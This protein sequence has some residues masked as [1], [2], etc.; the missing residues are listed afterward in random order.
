M[1][2]NALEQYGP[3]HGNVFVGIIWKKETFAF[4]SFVDEIGIDSIHGFEQSRAKRKDGGLGTEMFLFSWNRNDIFSSNVK[5]KLWN[6]LSQE[7][8]RC[9]KLSSSIDS[10]SRWNEQ[11]STVGRRVICLVSVGQ[12]IVTRR[13]ETIESKNLNKNGK[14]GSSV[15]F[16]SVRFGS[17]MLLK[18]VL[19]FFLIWPFSPHKMWA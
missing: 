18:K 11:C 2:A 17:S 6:I 4:F 13:K 7:S 15:Q 3:T 10:T 12:P 16:S 19:Q 1:A 14:R 5:R 9:R 8:Q